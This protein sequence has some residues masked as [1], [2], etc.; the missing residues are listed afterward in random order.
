MP[1]TNDRHAATL[2]AYLALALVW[3]SSFLL[4]KVALGAFTPAQVAL[5]RILIGAATLT[6]LM[7]VTRRAWP[8]E[9]RLWAHLT[10]VA[11]LLCVV[12]FL[13]FAWAGM[14]LP[15]GLSA[16]LN[17]T[18]PIWTA[19]ATTVAVRGARLTAWQALGVALGV[20]GV[21]LTMGVWR[22]VTDPVFLSSLPAQAACLAATASYG[23]AFAWMQRFV[24]GR[25]R[26][27]PLAVASVQLVAAAGIAVVLVPFVAVTPVVLDAVP[28]LSLLA[29]GV[30]GT[31]LA[32][33]W[34]TR[35]I[36]AWGSLA[37]ATVTYLTPLVGVVLGA[38]LL[39]ERLGWHEPAG[40]VVVVLS[41]MLVQRR[42][43]PVLARFRSARARWRSRAGGSDAAPRESARN[44]S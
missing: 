44:V 19:I 21:A 14:F 18:T 17:A 13:L 23:L 7:L 25:H 28:V 35:V 5:G 12:P 42:F 2:A 34:N 16:I 31:G 43:D 39:N 40:A 29:L 24:T 30:L 1:T 20:A 41:V 33:V 36:V 15:S 10:V 37:A 4:M 8:R 38:V 3:G 27:D 6:A 9:R 26:H 22:V 11:G 32:Y